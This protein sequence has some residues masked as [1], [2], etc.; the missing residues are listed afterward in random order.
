MMSEPLSIAISNTEEYP[1]LR[2]IIGK[3]NGGPKKYD[4]RLIDKA[5]EWRLFP[6][7]VI[8]LVSSQ[9]M[10]DFA[11]VQIN[12]VRYYDSFAQAFDCLGNDFMPGMTRDKVIRFYNRYYDSD[13]YEDDDGNAI[14]SPY[15]MKN[16]VVVL[17]L[18][19][20]SGH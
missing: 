19:I 8:K 20:I 16:K 15:I 4:A 7:K 6:G 17:G 2:D 9:N 12:D 10:R 3:G 1:F 5:T 13:E 11:Y 18:D 14:S